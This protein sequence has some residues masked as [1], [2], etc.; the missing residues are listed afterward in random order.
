MKGRRD[1]RTSSPT[2]ACN[3]YREE[4]REGKDERFFLA[5]GGM[6]GPATGGHRKRRKQARA[7]E[8]ISWPKVKIK[9]PPLTEGIWQKA[10]GRRQKAE[11]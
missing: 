11:G 5:A 2:H 9:R 7:A 10:E 4:A 1:R 3:P 6:E 8:E